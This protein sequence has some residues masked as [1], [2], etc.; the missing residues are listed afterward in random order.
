MRIGGGQS[1]DAGVRRRNLRRAVAGVHGREHVLER[2]H[3]RLVARAPALRA[4]KLLQIFGDGGRLL[5][6]RAQRNR[7]GQV[8]IHLD[9][10]HDAGHGQALLLSI[11]LKV[12]GLLGAVDHAGLVQADRGQQRRTAVGQLRQ[13]PA[14]RLFGQAV[15]RILERARQRGDGAAFVFVQFPFGH[16]DL[17]GHAFLAALQGDLHLDAAGRGDA[18]RHRIV[19][20][21]VGFRQGAGVSGGGRR[22]ARGGHP[23]GMAAAVGTQAVQHRRAHVGER[24]DAGARVHALGHR[25]G[26]GIR[27]GPCFVVDRAGG[28]GNAL[29][30]HHDRRFRGTGRLGRIDS[31]VDDLPRANDGNGRAKRGGAGRACQ[32]ADDG[33]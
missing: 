26:Q 25:N 10:A 28:G 14:R 31:G 16:V 6:G 22:D 33:H 20:L 9:H 21:K 11:R 27:H 8:Q 4:V 30:Q 7:A 23:L 24:A 5:L 1:A 17:H 2:A 12:D 13:R 15:Q 32:R 29:A 18:Q 3:Q 19:G